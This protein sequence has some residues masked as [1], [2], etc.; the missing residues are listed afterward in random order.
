L[1]APQ[2]SDAS[3]SKP[4]RL[5]G[6]W[7]PVLIAIAGAAA[8]ADSFSGPF[9]LDDKSS[10]M[11][12]PT[13]R[14]LW[15]IWSALRAPVK[16]GVGGRPVL[17]LSFGV[18]YA[19]GGLNAWGY[20]AANLAI[21]VLAG[22]ILFGIARRTLAR[23][24]GLS[25]ARFLDA[26]GAA[27]SDST[28]AFAI[29]LI[30]TVHPMQ[31]EAVTYVSQR[32]ESLMGLFYLLTLYG[33]IRYA[34]GGRIW[35]AAL[36]VVFCLAGMATK[37]VM[38]TAPV[39][40]LLYDRTFVGGTLGEAWRRRWRYY[41]G[42]AGTWLLLGFL[43]RDVHERGVGL[44]LG[45]AWWEYALME[46]RVVVRYLGLAVWPHPLVFDYGSW[47]GRPTWAA[48]PYV[49]VNLLLFA[50]AA[51]ALVR[52]VQRGRGVRALGFA[53]A[54][55]FLILAPTSSVV[56]VAGQP[57]AEHRMYLP[58]AAVAAVVVLGLHSLLGRRSP[59]VLLSL[60]VAL[61][62]LTWQRNGIYG[63]EERIWSD[64]VA[65]C[66]E[67]VR[68]HNNLGLALERIPGRSDEAIAQYEEALRL[69]PKYEEAHNNLGIALEKMPGRLD[70]AIAQYEE[71]LRLMP[72][73]P[74]A[75]YNLGSALARIP[76]RLDEA[77]AQ[78]E[79][80][81]R[82]KP[83][84]PKAHNNLGS[85]LARTPGRLDEAIAQYEEALRLEPDYAE[86]HYNLGNALAKM[87]RRLEEAIAQY[88]EALGLAP[89]VAAFHMNLAVTLLRI[90]GRTGEAVTQLREVLRLQ[91]G[92]APA[93]Q[94]LARIGEPG[95]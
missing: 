21:H 82:L 25:V 13:I 74:E 5:G 60:A 45:G 23:L 71:A 78:Y 54:W 95:P 53:W 92:N 51:W 57:M 42:L 9:T 39:V 26:G 94:L 15:P 77:I 73:V 30:W 64:T 41:L 56:A 86:A 65:K 49:A 85:A 32:A 43:L 18:N 46:S 7:P 2:P 87:P 89:D 67:N 36:S 90:P 48:A 14:H 37:E 80:A 59:P 69:D 33:F 75:H 81:L 55:V 31:T 63:S 76:G 10:I 68:A 19:L 38:V 93:R 24:R 4:P 50:A 47:A 6:I 66:P 34:E 12:N 91:P 20:H 58:L 70:E 88:E 22:V 72:D 28:L 61:G 44:G 16:S 8:Y 11:D 79:E 17:N 84:Y 29:A 35:N 83:D 3:E 62:W 52:P 40:V 1:N 27:C